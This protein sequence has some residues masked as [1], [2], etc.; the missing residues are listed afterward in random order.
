VDD[1]VDAYKDIDDSK[2]T[3]R[4]FKKGIKHNYFDLWPI[5]ERQVVFPCTCPR[6]PYKNDSRYN[7]Y[8]SPEI[9]H[10]PGTLLMLSRQ[11]GS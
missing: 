6:K 5:Q 7:M 10:A 11:R 1:I 8:N 3:Y 2:T 9:L 4:A